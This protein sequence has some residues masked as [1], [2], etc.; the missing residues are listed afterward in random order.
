MA[1]FDFVLDPTSETGAYIYITNDWIIDTDEEDGFRVPNN[2]YNLFEATTGSGT[3]QWE[4]RV[5]G[6]ATV[7]VSKNGEVVQNRDDP[8][9]GQF[10]GATGYGPSPNVD[11][12][13]TIFELRFPASRGTQQEFRTE[14]YT[15][16]EEYQ[17]ARMT[18]H[19]RTV[20]ESFQVTLGDPVRTVTKT[21]TKQVT[22]TGVAYQRAVRTVTRTRQVP[23]TRA[24]TAAE[25]AAAMHSSTTGG[26]GGGAGCT[27]TVVNAD[28]TEEEI[29]IPM[30]SE[31]NN[32]TIPDPNPDMW[33]PKEPSDDDGGSGGDDGGG[34]GPIETSCLQPPCDF[35]DP[36]ILITWSPTMRPTTSPS[37][38]PSFRPSVSPS[39]SPTIA[40]CYNG[41]KDAS[42]NETDVDCGGP[43]CPG[44][45]GFEAGCC[46]DSDCEGRRICVNPGSSCVASD[47]G[48]LG[49]CSTF[50]PSLSP[51][52]YPSE[53][54]S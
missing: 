25:A 49:A 53:S 37:P 3:E 41:I 33:D 42:T 44:S 40:L 24:R 51:S 36:T 52:K 31:P 11:F 26:G 30:V 14:R 32:F 34:Q 1:F 4:V 45:C 2:C 54:P 6:D 23:Y 5:Y 27:G 20:T 18:S 19:T 46:A 47:I 16:R 7:W 35:F 12:N 17:K 50:A 39:T 22:T 10:G 43:I 38:W 48:T 15:A 8:V 13:H 28:G 9:G 29:E 21:R